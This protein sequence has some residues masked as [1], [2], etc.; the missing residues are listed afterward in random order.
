MQETCARRCWT[1]ARGC[2]ST[3]VAGLRHPA[4]RSAAL[5]ARVEAFD[6]GTRVVAGDR[7]LEIG[8]EPLA[9]RFKVAGRTVQS[10]PTDGHFVRR[11]RLP[12][13]ARIGDAWFVSSSSGT[14]RPCTA[15]ARN[16]GASTGAASS[17][18]P[19]TTTR[20]A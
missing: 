13:F 18:V 3:R 19:T 9:F 4:A 20:S 11:F 7:V 8:H 2:G 1:A 6:G 17:C 15:S 12:P 10:S 5:R 16:G 14:T